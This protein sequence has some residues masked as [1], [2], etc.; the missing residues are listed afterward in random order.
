MYV[1]LDLYTGSRIPAVGASGA[2]MAVLMLYTMHFPRETI[3]VCW[4]IPMEMRWLMALYIIWDLHPV[5]LSLA[6]DKLFTG[7]GHAAHL[8]GLLFGFLYYWYDWHLERV[9]ERLRFLGWRVKARSLVRPS[10][11]TCRISEAD[12]DASRVDDVL[13]KISRYGQESLSEEERTI[14]RAASEKLKTRARE[15]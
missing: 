10:R 7:V 15:G 2:V 4:F 5:L 6:G 9:V 8:G 1:G 14:L 12:P 3:C 11:P 13:E